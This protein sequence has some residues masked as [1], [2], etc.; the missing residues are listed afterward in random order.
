M[1]E[2]D[3]NLI[4]DA[5]G[6]NADKASLFKKDQKTLLHLKASGGTEEEIFKTKKNL[7]LLEGIKWC[8][9]LGRW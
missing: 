6:A 7:T 1:A 2:I 4:N 9:R 3:W 5:T 8:R